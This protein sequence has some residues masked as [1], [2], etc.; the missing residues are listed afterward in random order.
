MCTAVA[1][2]MTSGCGSAVS[3]S[4]DRI[5]PRDTPTST[6]TPK[7]APEGMEQYWLR[8]VG[9]DAPAS[10]KPNRA[11]CGTPVASTVI[12]MYSGEGVAGCAITNPPKHLS[13]IRMSAGDNKAAYQQHDWHPETINGDAVEVANERT[14]QGDHERLVHFADRQVTVDMTSPDESI[15]DAATQSL[16]TVDTDPDTGC[17]V[18]TDA[19]DDGKPAPQ[20]DAHVLL[21]GHPTSA[22]GCVYVSGWLE[23]NARVSGDK[24]TALVNAV[25]AAPALTDSQAP[26]DT[27]CESVA[28]MQDPSDNPPMMLRFDYADSSTWTL[29]AKINWC[30]RWQSTISSGSVTRRITGALLLALPQLWM[31]YPDPDSMDP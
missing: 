11:Q 24:L 27:N 26:D 4:G 28:G 13:V 10:W 18:H 15:I 5:T 2:A 6:P 12:V 23:S 3:N 14:D 25:R 21:P 1:L 8:G 22:I 31:G 20:G 30:T 19:Y 17:V 7:P 29:V 9:V 16:Q